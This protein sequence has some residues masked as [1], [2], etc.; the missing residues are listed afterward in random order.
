MS[1]IRAFMG[2]KKV[3]HLRA[4]LAVPAVAAAWREAQGRE[5]SPEDP[6][7]LNRD[8]ERIMAAT[9]ARYAEP[10]PGALE[11]VAALR[12]RG[13][14]IGSTTGYTEPIMAALVPAARAQGYAPDAV[15]NS[16]EVPA[17]RPAPYMCYLNA[18]RLAVAPL[19]AMV[20]VGDTVADIQEGQNAGLWTVAVT[21]T[22]NELGLSPAEAAA[23][24]PLELKARL[25]AIRDRLREAGPHY[26]VES[27]A[28]CPRVVD[29]INQRL[30]RG[31]RP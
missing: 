2:L 3:D 25:N 29:E 21:R 4:L 12:A 13:L 19:E 10:V 24:A 20:K 5:P 15:V 27:L 22:G 8:L 11:A 28:D 26:V 9:V 23:L 6:A 30:A 17:G 16:S 18:V 7:L 31:E 14:A 1:Q